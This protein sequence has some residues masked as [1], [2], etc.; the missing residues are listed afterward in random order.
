[1]GARRRD[2]NK[3]QLPVTHLDEDDEIRPNYEPD[4]ERIATAV[5]RRLPDF[6]IIGAQKGGTTSLHH[7][8]TAHPD[9]APAAKKEIH[10]FDFH[11][12]R[13]VEWYRAH[14]PLQ[15]Q[16]HDGSGLTGEASPSYLFHPEAGARMRATVPDIKLIAMLRNP[17]DRA[18]SQYQMNVRKGIETLPFAAAIARNQEELQQGSAA[19]MSQRWRSFSYLSRGH[20]ADQLARWLALFPRE[21]FLILRSEDFFEDPVR[22]YDAALAFLGLPPWQLR[23]YEARK[24]GGYDESLDPETRRRLSDDFAPH[25]QRLYALLDQ[26]F[27]WEHDQTVASR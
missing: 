11:F 8:L 10:F 2:S 16:G 15:V 12:A 23:Q 9:V 1:M 19:V 17:V 27:G 20:Y 5:Q 13:G 6:A 4:A 14:F 26:D 25:N 18:Y 3:G 7:Y 24:S 22:A 21:Q